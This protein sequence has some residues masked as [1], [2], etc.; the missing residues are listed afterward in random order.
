MKTLLLKRR[1]SDLLALMLICT[2]FSG[3][4]PELKSEMPPD[5][6]YWLEPTVLLNPPALQLQVEV[7]PGLSTDHILLLERD[8]RLNVFAGAYW[9][10][11]LQPLLESL[12]QR[13]LTAGAG[14]ERM[15]VLVERFFALEAAPDNPPEVEIR[16]LL[17]T[18]EG[19]C[20]FAQSRMAASNRLRDIVAAHQRLLDELA[21][22]IARF[23]RSGIC[24]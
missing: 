13:S 23:G 4:M 1:L 11:N 19:N 14:G 20:R 3:C 21:E 2:L 24:G 10:D 7:A 16:A 9:P 22:G 12:L 18:G 5:R 8:Q 6:V 17:A 15:H